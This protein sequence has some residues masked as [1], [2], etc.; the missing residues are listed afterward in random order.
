[1][2]KAAKVIV[3]VAA[4][5]VGIWATGGIG[6]SGWLYNTSTLA[7]SSMGTA[8]PAPGLLQMAGTGLSSMFSGLSSSISSNKLSWGLAGLSAASTIMG[9]VSER[10][11]L[12]LQQ[13]EEA[14]RM[15]LVRLQALQAEA[16]ALKQR[17]AASG[18]AIAKA[19]AQ[20]QNISGRSFLAFV[21]DQKRET[22][23]QIDT[24]RVNAEAG[25][26]TSQLRIRQFGEQRTAALFGGAG[27]VARSLLAV[28]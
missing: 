9:T 7:A 16:T 11:D 3:P 1:M 6:A 2:G 13:Q 24:I 20:G 5:G 17:G 22:R 14:R 25:V 27:G 28:V 18:A 19:A 8:L 4:V 15:R 21:E 26:Q 12:L 23:Q 10:D